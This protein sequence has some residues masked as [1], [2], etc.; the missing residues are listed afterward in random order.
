[1]RNL[2][3]S[4]PLGL[5]LWASLSAFYRSYYI[6]RYLVLHLPPCTSQAPEDSAAQDPKRWGTT[7]RKELRGTKLMLIR[8]LS[9]CRN[10]R[11]LRAFEH[12]SSF[13]IKR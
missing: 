3:S 4:I 7:S 9:I 8:R 1:M 5:P 12:L 11:Q 10:M 2:L 6:Y 13:L